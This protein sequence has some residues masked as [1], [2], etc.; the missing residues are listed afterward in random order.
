MKNLRF[1]KF[2]FVLGVFSMVLFSSCSDDDDNGTPS[3]QPQNIVQLVQTTD[4]LS[5]LEAALQQTNLVG[6]LQGDG[7]FTVFA[8]T[9]AAFQ[10]LLDSNSSWNDLSDIPN[11][12]LTSV[13]LFH[14]VNG[15]V[16]SGDLT[17]TY[18]PTLS[19]NASGNNISLQIQVTGGIDFNGSASPESTDLIDI[20]ASNGV[21][22]VIDEVMLPPSIVELASRNSNFTSLVAALQEASLV[23]ALEGGE[24][25]TVFAPNNMAFA[26]LLESN[27]DWSSV[28][29][30][31]DALLDNVLKFHVLSDSFV[32]ADLSD[33]YIN[34]LATGPNSENLSLQIQTTDG[35]AFNGDALPQTTDIVGTNGV[36]HEINKVMLPPNIVSLALNNSNFSSLIAALTDSRHTID[37]VS[38]LS[39]DGPFTVF[40]PDNA[41]F[42]ALL[43]SENTWNS[44][45]DI[46]I[47]TLEAVLLYHV[48]NGSNVQSDQLV[49][50]QVISMFGSGDVTVDLSGPALETGSGQTVPIVT[51]A[52]DIQGTNGV[53]HQVQQVLL[54]AN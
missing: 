48:V 39:G 29:D 21:V 44:I 34:T 3:T 47:A 41:A 42:Q 49:D 2:A 24:P 54:P 11:D 25:L 10:S 33:A 31:P 7:P 40:A 6:A 36:I 17:D 32:A 26:E 38:V 52:I 53:I 9:N 15:S 30:I 18:V 4:N 1:T 27:D 51:S 20:M 43:D 22:H 37:F 28:A 5:I 8:P 19:T 35:I 13:L 14:V 12:L 16:M 46:P 45:S 50:D 23:S